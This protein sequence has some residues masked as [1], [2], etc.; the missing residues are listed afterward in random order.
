MN[1]LWKILLF[2]VAALEIAAEL[3]WGDDENL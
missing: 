2:T 3:F 1:R